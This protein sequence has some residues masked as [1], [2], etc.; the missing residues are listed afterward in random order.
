M[1]AVIVLAN[2]DTELGAALQ[3][4][5]RVPVVEAVGRCH[6]ILGA[7]QASYTK[8]AQTDGKIRTNKC[9]HPGILIDLEIIY[10]TNYSF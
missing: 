4:H 6:H 1:L 5:L 9:Y 3:R 7:H 8:S 10:C 2:H